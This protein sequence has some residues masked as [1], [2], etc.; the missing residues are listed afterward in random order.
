MAT[1]SKIHPGAFVRRNVIPA[2]ISVKDAAARLDIGRPALSNFLNGKA[3]LSPEMA[4]RLEKAFGADR[5]QLLDMQAAYDQQEQLVNEKQ[6]AVR[7]FVPSF[8]T[9]KAR[10]IEAWADSHIE[11]RTH[12]AVLIRK[13]VHSTGDDLSQVDFPGYDN[14]QRK[15]LDGCVEAG[16]ATPWIPEGK[17]YWE[18]GADKKPITK[19]EDD[20]NTRLISLDP[21]Q[22]TKTTFVFVTPRNWPGKTAWEKKKNEAGQWRAVRAL[23]ASDLEQW[24]EQSVPAQI[25]LAEQLHLPMAG[26]ETLDQAWR[27][28]ATVSERPLLPELFAPSIAAHRNTLKTWLSKPSD[29]SFVITADSKEEAFAFLACL[30]DD[31]DLRAYKDRAAIF[32]SP[33]ALQTLIAS[34]V[35]F[36]PIVHSADAERE[37]IDV[38]RRLHCIVFHPRNSVQSEADVA[39][40]LLDHETFEKALVAMGIEKDEVDRLSRESGRSPTVLR[41]RLSS[42][43][44]I[45]S[46]AWTT[47]NDTT[48]SLVPIALIGAWHVESK[49]DCEIVAY[50]A[51]LTYETIERNVACLLRFEDSPVW[52][53]GRYYGVVSKIDVL[54]SIATAITT[55][56]LDRFF[57]AAE[58]VLSEIDP[59]LELPEKDRWSARLFG[60]KRDHSDALREGICETLILLAV[61]GNSLF[62][63]HRIDV[64]V[65]VTDLIHK[66]LTPLTLEKLLSH[67]RHLPRYAEAAPEEFLRVLREDLKGTAPTILGLL[68]PVNKN[69]TF[70]SPLRTGLCWALECLAWKPQNLP[71]VI[72]ILAQL[73]R[74]KIDDNWTNKPYASLQAIFRSW[75]P[76]TAASVD[77]RIKA[78]E[79]VARKFPDI[80]WEIALEEVKPGSRVGHYS[81]RPRW[82]SDASGAGQIASRGDMYRFTRRALDLLLAWPAYDEKKL[83]ELVQSLQSMGEDD[84]RKVWNLIDAWAQ[85]AAEPAKAVL[86]ERIRRF[87]LTQRGRRLEEATRDDAHEVY[88]RLQPQDPVIRHGWL[89][90]DYWVQESFGE[91]AEENFDYR[92][93]SERIDRLRRE[94]STEI[95]RTQGFDGLFNLLFDSGAASTVG[96]YA[97]TCIK[98]VKL[99]CQFILRCLLATGDLQIK[100]ELGAQGLLQSIDE[101]SRS[102]VLKAAIKE[103]P[104]ADQVRLLT[105]A[106]FGAAT[107]RLLDQYDEDTRAAY[108]KKVFPSCSLFT[109]S[110]LAELI[111]NLLS[112]KRPLAAFHA[113]HMDFKDI[114]TSRLMRLLREIGTVDA[115]QGDRFKP[116]SYYISQAF[117]SLNGRARITQNEMARLEFMFIDALH[118]S[119]YGI[120]NLENQIACSPALYVQAVALAYKRSDDGED[121]SEWRIE[122]PTQ[123][124]AAATAAHR[125]LNRVSAIPGTGVKNGEIEAV[126]LSAWLAE[127]RRLCHKFA[128][129]TVGDQC[130]GQ[131]LAKTPHGEDGLWPCRSVCESME[132]IASPEIARGFYIG[133]HNA[134]GVHWR[135]EGGAQEREL[136]AKYHS[137]AERLHFEFPYVGGIL[138]EIAVSY[139]REAGW[140]DAEAKIDKRLRQ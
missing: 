2:G 11:A 77:Q 42:N 63:N 132:E 137:L 7:A 110:E 74:Q 27:R 36:I 107:W 85:H 105:L 57:E 96:F 12:L 1:N 82:R 89:F 34:A 20:Y 28:W 117:S 64:E 99:R 10:Q 44:A 94:A 123:K 48:K 43:A 54:Y 62:L 98:T 139:E 86:R 83:G 22:R 109:P 140:Q 40:D 16:S 90:A 35:P 49:A 126:T 59:A 65:R 55:A 103:I 32:T 5:K 100:A 38:Y 26:Y 15:G 73:S 115:E 76:Q 70:G 6:V 125:L 14:A 101:N 37:L 127:V 31:D 41:R 136:A 25:W 111:D 134:R 93:R 72:Q 112:A 119:E 3:A 91:I 129:A 124:I 47:D 67:D 75:M 23:D 135:G 114:E 97:A 39:L 88:N 8:L 66:L 13:L 92:T 17:S 121:P 33:T 120:P 4:V 133:V 130:L 45:R 87:A 68:T 128:R 61:H 78:L 24:L 118:D 80:A 71:H 79:L 51:D 53:A 116:E 69:A 138:E 102:A 29:R 104:P 56:D 58:Y 106:P 95:W 21:P 131:L 30:F 84:Q 113:V 9:I 81:Y 122:N 52:S 108:W 18:F 19:A 60:K 46:P 50:V